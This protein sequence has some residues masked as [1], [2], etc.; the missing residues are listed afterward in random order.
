MIMTKIELKNIKYAEFSSEETNCYTATLYVNGKRFAIV[1]NE[2][3]GGSDMQDPISPFTYK[4]LTKLQ[5]TIAKEYPKWGSEFGDGE[6]YDATLEI[7][8]GDLMNQWHTD[9]DIKKTL[10]KISF[11]RRPSC[12]E[13][14]TLGSVS[15]A[16]K[17]GDKIRKKILADNPN[18]V[19]LNDISIEE[20]RKYF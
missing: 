5:E 11:V 7:V 16:K 4:D 6:E 12:K 20:A 14:Y 18:A 8:C 15:Q 2:G 10:K 9:N 13:I 17:D 19:I 1:S 3:R